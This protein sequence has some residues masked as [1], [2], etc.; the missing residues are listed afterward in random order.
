M[1]VHL[2][3][4]SVV[5]C[6]HV[7]D[8]ARREH[9]RR[10]DRQHHEDSR[11]RGDMPAGCRRSRPARPSRMPRRVELA[12]RVSMAMLTVLETLAPTERA[13]FVLREV[14]DVPYDE[15]A[16]AVDKT[17]AAVRLIAHRA[18]DHVVARRP[19]CGW[20]RRAI[21]CHPGLGRRCARSPG[22]RRRRAR[23]CDERD[24][25]A[26]ADHPCLL[27]R[28]P[29]Q[30]GAARRRSGACAVERRS[31]RSCGSTVSNPPDVRRIR[32]EPHGRRD[33]AI[34]GSSRYSGWLRASP[35][36]V[37]GVVTL[38]YMTWAMRPST[39]C[40]RVWQWSA[41]MPGLSAMNAMS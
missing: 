38:S 20:T 21:H 41:Q 27:R 40:G 5:R 32:H 7:D 2:S 36:M 14:F 33:G 19:G 37:N 26:G 25:R 13:V 34:Q 9:W 16:G 15:I 1:P 10:H 17:P 12:E 8:T 11:D 39:A 18:K 3:H 22:R 24:R 23:R 30:A 6:L 28:E 35:L 4:A 29:R 31:D